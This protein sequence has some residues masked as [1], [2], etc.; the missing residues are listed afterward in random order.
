MDE[1]EIFKVS[2]HA[3]LRGVLPMTSTCK[4]EILTPRLQ[5]SA[6]LFLFFDHPHPLGMII[7]FER[8]IHLL[9][10]F[11][12]IFGNFFVKITLC[13]LMKS[14]SG[15]HNYPCGKGDVAVPFPK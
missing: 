15:G 7:C 6:F 4:A 9:R 11:D 2:K 8:I 5:Q 3:I 14:L 12:Y 13:L 1:I 10:H